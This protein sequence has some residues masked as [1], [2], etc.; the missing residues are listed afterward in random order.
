MEEEEKLKDLEAVEKL[1]EMGGIM[2]IIGE[3]LCLFEYIA[4]PLFLISLELWSQPQID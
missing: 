4:C 2:M 3:I 1:R